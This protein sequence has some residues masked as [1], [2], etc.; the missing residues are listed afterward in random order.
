MR[1]IYF[2]PFFILVVMYCGFPLYAQTT[3]STSVPSK[4]I[5]P[6]Y[7]KYVDTGDKM[8]DLNVFEHAK[9]DYA[10]KHG[11]FPSYANT[12]NAVQDSLDYE[13]AKTEWFINNSY[14]PVLIETGD[15]LA[16]K[17]NFERAKA[18]W[19][20][21]FP[22]QYK[23]ITNEIYAKTLQ[24]DTSTSKTANTIFVDYPEMKNTGNEFQ[25]IED[26]HKAIKE[27]FK[28]HPEVQ[29]ELENQDITEEHQPSTM[30]KVVPKN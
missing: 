24:I 23:K 9:R 17:E 11:S 5:D 16:D 28:N 12:G 18:E 27:W 29:K 6:E 2:L 4:Y 21:K 26:Y 1:K 25:D 10:K 8:N 14:Y 13:K 3:T 19:I 22:E 15:V 7:P 30:T 20:K